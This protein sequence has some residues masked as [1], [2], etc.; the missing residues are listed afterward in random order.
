MYK[1]T[2]V[3][4]YNI[5]LLLHVTYHNNIISESKLSPAQIKAI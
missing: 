2:V 5:Q 4:D 1:I 3:L